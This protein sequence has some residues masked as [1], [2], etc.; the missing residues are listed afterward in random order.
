MRNYY[1]TN[2]S[3]GEYDVV[4]KDQQYLALRNQRTWRSVVRAENTNGV[5]S[6]NVLRYKRDT[7][8]QPKQKKYGER[9]LSHVCSALIKITHSPNLPCT[10]EEN[11]RRTNV[12]CRSMFSNP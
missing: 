4:D 12:V 2:R 1:P 9:S 6:I 8:Y 5:R 11:R 3:K 10:T 7:F